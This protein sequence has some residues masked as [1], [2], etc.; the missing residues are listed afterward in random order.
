MSRRVSPG[1]TL[2]AAAPARSRPIAARCCRPLH[3]PSRGIGRWETNSSAKGSTLP[4]GSQLE[5]GCQEGTRAPRRRPTTATITDQRR[6]GGS[7]TLIL[8]DPLDALVQRQ[9]VEPLAP[10][11]RRPDAEPVEPTAPSGLPRANIRSALL[12]SSPC[13]LRSATIGYARPR[14]SQ[15]WGNQIAGSSAT[16]VAMSR[17]ES[18]EK[19]RPS[20][21][22]LRP[23]TSA[24]AA[25]WAPRS[26]LDHSFPQRVRDA[27]RAGSLSGRGMSAI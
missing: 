8:H 13:G 12:A 26:S 19:R 18:H 2:V 23:W 15:K 22:A 11:V 9:L 14:K 24:E 27:G 16:S 7:A 5:A 4:G 20:A 17:R 21:R 6:I 10:A 1:S 25:L 3:E